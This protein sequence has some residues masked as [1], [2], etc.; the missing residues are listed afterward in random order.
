ML[1]N[2]KRGVSFY[3]FDGVEFNDSDSLEASKFGIA[4]VK[5]AG[6]RAE[7]LGFKAG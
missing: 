3:F 7:A 6:R 5:L 2:Q 4:K 1:V